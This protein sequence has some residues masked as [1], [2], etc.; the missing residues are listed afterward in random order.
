MSPA[1]R[2]LSRAALVEEAL[3]VPPRLVH[4]LPD[5]RQPLRVARQV[6]QARVQPEPPVV[7]VVRGLPYSLEAE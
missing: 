2:A 4:E 1:S 6:L 5:L 7:P 3:G